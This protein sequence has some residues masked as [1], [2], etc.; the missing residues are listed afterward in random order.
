MK[1]QF[2]FKLERGRVVGGDHAPLHLRVVIE[3]GRLAKATLGI[4]QKNGTINWQLSVQPA[5]L[6]WAADCVERAL[7]TANPAVNAT[8][9]AVDARREAT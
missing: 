4:E 1:T 8:P 2:D 6:T 9:K 7:V 3:G 5:A